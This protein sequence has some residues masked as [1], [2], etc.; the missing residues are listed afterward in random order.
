MSYHKHLHMIPE[1]MW[2][3][4]TKWIDKG[5]PPGSF[6]TA[7]LSNDFM[8]AFK[9]ADD[10]NTAFMK[11]WASFLYN[12]APNG[13]HGSPERFQAWAEHQGLEGIDR[14][15]AAAEEDPVGGLAGGVM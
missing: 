14:L 10:T 9:R 3:G 15:R 1:H 4:I 12:Y 6:L 5:I 13:C 11:N 7:V 2:D 8:G